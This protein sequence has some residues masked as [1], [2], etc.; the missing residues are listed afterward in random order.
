MHHILRMNNICTG[1]LL[2]SLWDIIMMQAV[3]EK[4]PL[5]DHKKDETALEFGG[6]I[7]SLLS[8]LT[9]KIQYGNC[10]TAMDLRP[11]TPT[12]NA[13]RTGTRV[14]IENCLKNKRRARS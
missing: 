9:L 14:M 12:E 11:V 13:T 10:S 8:N 4:I 6:I 1:L 3:V 7:F 5:I 2:L